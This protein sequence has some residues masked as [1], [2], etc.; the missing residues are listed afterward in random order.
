MLIVKQLSHLLSTYCIQG[1]L[2]SALQTLLS[3]S[4]QCSVVDMIIPILKT[5]QL[6][7]FK[8]ATQDYTSKKWIKKEAELGSEPRPV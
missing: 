2:L 6:R 4:Q 5:H 1:T 7:Y 8:K 3:S